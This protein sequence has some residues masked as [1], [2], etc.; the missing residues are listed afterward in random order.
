[1]FRPRGLLPPRSLPPSCQDTRQPW[2]L[3]PSRTPVVTFRCI[4]YASRPNGP[5]TARGLSPPKTCSLVGRSRDFHPLD[6]GLVGRYIRPWCRQ[7]EPP[8]L[9]F[10]PIALGCL[11]WT[12]LWGTVR[13]GVVSLQNPL[14]HILI[15]RFL[16]ETR[17]GGR[18]AD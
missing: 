7:A 10:P 16:F 1:M 14:Q 4:G 18:K 2:R 11:L 9:G 17:P 12:T 5:L 3:R 15:V 13:H 6:E 8:S